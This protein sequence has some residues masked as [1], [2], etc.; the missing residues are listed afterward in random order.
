[1]TLQ[2]AKQI[3]DEGINQS[4]PHPD[5]G[6][7]VKE[8]KS[9]IVGKLLAA[10]K[11]AFNLIQREDGL[12]WTLSTDSGW[13]KIKEIPLGTKNLWNIYDY[14]VIEEEIE[15]S[16]TNDVA[17][18]GSITFKD[19]HSKNRS[20]NFN[21]LTLKKTLMSN[22]IDKVKNLLLSPEEKL[23]RKHGLKN[24]NGGYTN[25]FKE[26]AIEKLCKDKEA[27]IIADVQKIDAEEERK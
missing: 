19:H 16:E 2:E 4:S 8:I 11:R 17:G 10:G 26:L 13:S 5:I 3:N 22:I 21:S 15:H 18:D 6:K 7:R 1:M 25:D 23:L 14:E 20:I 9:G 12:G 27:E 24:E